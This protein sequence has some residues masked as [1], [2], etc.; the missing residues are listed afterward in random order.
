[1]Q[2]GLLDRF[3]IST[4][5]TS[6]IRLCSTFSQLRSSLS[7][8][9]PVFG[10]RVYA[11]ALTLCAS[12]L[13]YSL[14]RNVGGKLAGAVAVLTLLGTPSF[15]EPSRHYLLETLISVE[16]LALLF[17][18]ARYYDGRRLRDLLSIGAILSAG[19]LTKFNFFFYAV[20]LFIVPAGIECYE[21]LR[22]RHKLASA[23]QLVGLSLLCRSS[24]QAHGIS[25]G[26]PVPERFGP[27]QQ[28]A[29]RRDQH[30][31]P[32]AGAG[33]LSNL[34]ELFSIGDSAGSRRSGT[35]CRLF[36]SAQ[37]FPRG[38]ENHQSV[39]TCHSCGCHGWRTG[40]PSATCLNRDG[41]EH[42]LAYRSCLLIHT[43]FRNDWPPQGA[44]L[45]GY[46]DSALPALA[47]HCSYGSHTSG[48]WEF[49]AYLRVP[50]LGYSPPPSAT[51]IG[52]EML[53]RDIASHERRM[54]GTKPGEFVFF[55]YHEH[56][57]PHFGSVEFYL[58]SYGYHPG[59]AYR[60]VLES[61]GRR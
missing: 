10:G 13:L 26:P 41:A 24:S 19:L 38:F 61:G 45:F 52:S 16:V 15:I 34:L 5:F 42:P 22:G 14:T 27:A 54:D 40:A 44:P 56:S 48:P 51:P 2:G 33:A 30:S 32:L 7:A 6:C 11:Q 28:S 3:R 50:D 29:R 36:G 21:A 49:P 12:I 46:S 1:M 57:G 55:L 35:V 37:T 17:F 47:P 18:I 25:S 4:C 8:A 60:S 43:V 20:W 58:P 9:D 59:W 23:A 53:A 39:S 31:K